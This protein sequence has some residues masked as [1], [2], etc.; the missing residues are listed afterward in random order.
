MLRVARCVLQS[1][2]DR[3]CRDKVD[4]ADVDEYL[5]LV[6]C[7]LAEGEV[8]IHIGVRLIED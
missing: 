3:Q 5:V 2:C 6:V 8:G 7:E 1:E 4:V